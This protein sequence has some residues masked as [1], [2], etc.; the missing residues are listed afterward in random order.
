MYPDRE[1]SRLA[2]AKAVIRMDIAVRRVECAQAA[3]EVA[4]PLEWLDRAL[5]FWRRV[6]PLAK[7]AVVPLGLLLRRWVLRR[8]KLLG[9]L[10]RWGPLAA[11]AVRGLNLATGGRGGPA[12]EE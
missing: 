12:G 9:A 4:R 5:A 6:S 3:A 10:L 8:H 7:L 11:G 1:L 2:A